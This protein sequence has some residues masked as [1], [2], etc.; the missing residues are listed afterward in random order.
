METLISIAIITIIV[1]VMYGSYC[2]ATQSINRCQGNIDTT[3]QAQILLDTIT[4]QIRTA[5]DA[6]DATKSE[7]KKCFYGNDSESG[8]IILQL[9]TNTGIDQRNLYNGPVQ[10]TYKYDPM[11]GIIYYSQRKN[12]YH[13]D[14]S[15]KEPDNQQILAEGV[16]SID[17]TF[18]DG[19]KYHRQWPV[20]DGKPLPRAVKID[21]TFDSENQK[22]PKKFTT[23]A[24]VSGSDINIQ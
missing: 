6:P 16:A 5:Y 7:S 4:Q 15:N 2:A 18:S 17:L 20:P 14:S 22:Q 9:I 19:K 10:A 8:G 24:C 3:R 13:P 12:I 21:V 23:I 11:K 1:S